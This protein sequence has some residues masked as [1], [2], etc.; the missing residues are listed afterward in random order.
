M[1]GRLQRHTLDDG[2]AAALQPGDLVRVVGQQAQ[3]DHV[4]I[5]QHLGRYAIVAQVGLVAEQQIGLHR[6]VADV[7][8]VI[9]AQLLQQADAPPL[10]T[11][12]EQHAAPLGG[13]EAHRRGQLRAAIAAP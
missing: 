5:A 2:Q 4:Q 12:V 1:D 9:G 10:L 13:N 3:G 6:V 11:K 8:Q 7:L